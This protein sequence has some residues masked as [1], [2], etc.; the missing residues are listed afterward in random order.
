MA[1]WEQFYCNVRVTGELHSEKDSIGK[2]LKITMSVCTFKIFVELFINKV[3]ANVPMRTTLRITEP[4]PRHV[5]CVFARIRILQWLQQL[6]NK[7]FIN[8]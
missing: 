2:A 7:D 4:I 5:L 1:F 6:N 3:Q 8:S